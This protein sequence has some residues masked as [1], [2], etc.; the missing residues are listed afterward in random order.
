MTGVSDS[1]SNP[2][3]QFILQGTGCTLNEPPSATISAPPTAYSG[4][5]VSVLS[6]A[7]APQNNLTLHSIEWLSPSG[8]WTVSTVAVSGGNSLR[9]YGI[10]FP[11]TGVWTVRTGASTDNG[12]TWVYS[13]SVQINVTSGIVQYVLQT[14]S[15]PASGMQSWYTPSPVVQQT[16]QVQL[17]NPQ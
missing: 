16:Y 1:S 17:V 6:T 2:V 15:V 3:V 11:T 8:A 10:T 5:P 14:M 12:V 4:S 9:N 13:S 7:F